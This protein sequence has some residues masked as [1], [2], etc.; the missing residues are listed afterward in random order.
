MTDQ[1]FYNARKTDPFT[2][3]AAAAQTNA[4]TAM[5]ST[6]LRAFLKAG[7]RGLTAEQAAVECQYVKEQA[8]KRVSDLLRLE[9]IEHNGESRRGSSGRLQ[10]VHVI[11][12]SGKQEIFNEWERKWG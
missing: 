1:L 12:P 9:H 10:L 4:K 7:E 8:Y 2:S 6:L 5:T 3:H 11:T